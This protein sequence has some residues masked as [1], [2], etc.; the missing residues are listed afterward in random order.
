M[1]ETLAFDNLVEKLH[2]VLEGLPDYRTGHKLD[3][4]R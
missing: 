2:R 4:Y 3:Y 1:S